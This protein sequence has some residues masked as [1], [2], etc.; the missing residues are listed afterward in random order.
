MSGKRNLFRNLKTYNASISIANGKM[1]GAAG[2]GEILIEAKDSKGNSTP[3]LLREALYVPGLGPNN[4]VS[5]RCIE[6]AGAIVVFGESGPNEV[7]IRMNGEEIAVANLQPNSYVLLAE[8]GSYDENR[9]N[10]IM[11]NHAELGK[12]SG[13]LREWHERLGHLGFEDVKLLAKTTPDMSITGSMENL[14]CESSQLGKQSRK[15]NSSP[16]THRATKPLDLIHSDVV[17]P[18]ATTLLGGARYFLLFIDD[19]SQYTTVYTIPRKSGV[20]DCFKKFKAMVET[21]Q[22]DKIRRFRSDGGGEFVS[23]GFT[24]VLDH[25]GILPEQSAPY[26]PEQNGV[27]ERANRTVIGRAKAMLFATGLK[28]EMWGEAV[29]TAVFLKNRS[30]MR[31]IDKGMTPLQLFTGEIP[32][33]RALIPFGARGY[34]HVPKEVRTK[35]EPNSIRCIFTGYAGSNQFRVLIDRNIHITRDLTIFKAPLELEPGSQPDT[36]VHMWEEDYD[37]TITSWTPIEETKPRTPE[38]PEPE[39][40]PPLP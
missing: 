3:I 2:K 39:D 37:D 29:H 9:A 33:L 38:P 17:G 12:V 27:S 16:A 19:Y 31:A 5:V 34:K 1:I 14:T 13:T 30:P 20:I 22:D 21:Q 40:L 4:L 6:K 7:S 15:P 36:Y 26:S 28:D 11:A 24:Q 18:M 23:K 32:K 10:W 25:A 8:A 35:W